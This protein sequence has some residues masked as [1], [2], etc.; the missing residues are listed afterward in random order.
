MRQHLTI[1]EVDSQQGQETQEQPWNE[2]IPTKTLQAR[3]VP[4]HVR[5]RRREG[6]LRVSM[7]SGGHW[8]E[9]RVE[10]LA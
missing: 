9:I 7:R 1:P 8:P 4:G 5:D 10:L 3:L 2:G 6:T